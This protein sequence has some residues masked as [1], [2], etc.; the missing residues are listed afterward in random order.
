MP[1]R[2]SRNVFQVPLDCSIDKYFASLCQT[3]LRDWRTNVFLLPPSFSL[4]ACTSLSHTTIRWLISSFQRS[5]VF[6]LS[7]H[8]TLLSLAHSCLTIG[9][10]WIPRLRID[11]QRT[12]CSPMW[13]LVLHPVGSSR[14][15][16]RSIR[17]NLESVACRA[18]SVHRDGKYMHFCILEVD[19]EILQ[20]GAVL[21]SLA[22]HF[23][24]KGHKEIGLTSTKVTIPV[25]FDVTLQLRAFP[26][27]K[28]KDT[29][30]SIKSSP[31]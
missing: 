28:F 30:R 9:L 15:I 11:S 21:G 17:S 24:A 31:C 10:S 6:S 4:L 25:D 1:S 20:K 19:P 14:S 7:S 8:S 22:I 23:I 12:C 29:T 18:V 16:L 27:P 26:E 5:I 2:W 3:S 13:L